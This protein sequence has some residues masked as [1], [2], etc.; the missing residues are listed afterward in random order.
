MDERWPGNLFQIFDAT[1]KKNLDFVV[2]H[3]NV[4]QEIVAIL[5]F[6]RGQMGR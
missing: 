6:I 2:N 1:K 3:L 5:D 4:L